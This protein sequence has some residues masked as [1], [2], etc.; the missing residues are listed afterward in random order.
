V[1][2]NVATRDTS[3]THPAT[4]DAYVWADLSTVNGQCYRFVAYTHDDFATSEER[5]TVRPDW[6]RCPQV[7]LKQAE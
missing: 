4:S 7:V 5:C 2:Q 1:I 3:G 6:D